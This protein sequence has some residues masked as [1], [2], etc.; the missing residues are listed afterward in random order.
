MQH[1]YTGKKL[2]HGSTVETQRQYALHNV[3]LVRSVHLVIVSLLQFN[4]RA[5][6]PNKWML[7]YWKDASIFKKVHGRRITAKRAAACTEIQ[8][9]FKTV[10]KTFIHGILIWSP[11]CQPCTVSI[12]QQ[13]F[14][15]GNTR[16]VVTQRHHVCDHATKC[17]AIRTD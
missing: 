1:E 2:S 8:N 9:D 10:N 4:F 12:H 6:W 14:L 7:S 5:Q 16:L 3:L 17:R 11:T 13:K 15:F